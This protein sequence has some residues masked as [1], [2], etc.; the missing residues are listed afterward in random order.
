[1]GFDFDTA[2]TAPFRMQ[3]GLRKMANDQPNLTPQRPGSAHHL[4]KLH[5]LGQRWQKA[6]VA[7]TGFDATPALLALYEHAHHHHPTSW[8]WDG[9]GAQAPLL[10][11]T[12]GQGGRVDLLDGEELGLHATVPSASD[13]GQALRQQ[14]LHSLRALPAP[15][16]LTGLFALAFEE[17]LAIVDGNDASIPWLAVALPS[18][19]APEAKVGGH[20]A[21]V[22]APVADNALL[23]K[24]AQS[25]TQLVCEAQRW[26]R[27]VWTITDSPTLSAHPLHSPS[28]RW[29]HTPVEQATFR[30]EHQTF[31][32]VPAHRLAVF[33]IHVQ[34]QALAQVLHGQAH[35]AQVLHDALASMSPAVLAYRGLQ[36]VRQ[37]LLQW[38]HTQAKNAA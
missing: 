29:Q 34:T 3:P 20:F 24:A 1:M 23:L 31:L 27:F 32:P 16:R 17:D 19:W 33:T 25:L 11:L 7:R 35:R 6:L 21:Q 4:E 5:V 14:A 2:V 38:L 15:W 8:R 36:A 13:Q 28:Q 37:P 12:V 26:E 30:T 9:L 22:H 18:H 10:G